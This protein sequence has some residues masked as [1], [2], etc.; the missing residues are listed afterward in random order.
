MSFV[1]AGGRVSLQAGRVRLKGAR[2][3]ADKPTYVLSIKQNLRTSRD[4]PWMPFIVA[5]ASMDRNGIYE[6]RQ[7]GCRSSW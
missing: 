3:H 4:V 2:M 7:P 1:C 6:A 5:M